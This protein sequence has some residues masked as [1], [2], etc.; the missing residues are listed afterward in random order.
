M[1]CDI[2]ERR[3]VESRIFYGKTAIDCPCPPMVSRGTS[4]KPLLKA[5]VPRGTSLPDTESGEDLSQEVVGAYFAGHRH[6]RLV[7]EPQVLRDQL[8][9]RPY[10][11]RRELSG[12]R[13]QRL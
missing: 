4:E 10:A 13:F 2:S 5:V 8:R 1:G 9:L 6:E 12:G 7:R 3:S 11:G